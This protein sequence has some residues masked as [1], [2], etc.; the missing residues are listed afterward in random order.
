MNDDE[1]LF[2]DEESEEESEEIIP[3]WRLLIADDEK[4][5]HSITEM[6]LKDFT[7][8]GLGIN[9]TSAYSAKEA[10]EILNMEPD[11]A[12]GVLDVVME[13]DD[14]GFQ[15]VEHIRGK[16]ENQSM[17]LIMR[18]GQPGQIGTEYQV[19]LKHP[20]NDIQLKTQTTDARFKAMLHLQLAEYSRMAGY[21]IDEIKVRK[22]I[23]DAIHEAA[24]H[25]QEHAVIEKIVNILTGKE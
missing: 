20:I 10:I 18:T 19:V 15:I 7:F 6:V 1:M 25:I 2:E 11:F 13:E 14:A 21:K 12:V 5:I 16:Q 4:E 24:S 9:M 8:A 17:R 22:K 3:F 23:N